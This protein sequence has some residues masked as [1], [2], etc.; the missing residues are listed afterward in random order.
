L[1][2]AD[3]KRFLMNFIA[4]RFFQGASIPLPAPS[5]RASHL[6]VAQQANVAPHSAAAGVERSTQRS[7]PYLGDLARTGTGSIKTSSNIRV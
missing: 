4:W 3:L 6:D 1:Q 7:S 5:S 2:A